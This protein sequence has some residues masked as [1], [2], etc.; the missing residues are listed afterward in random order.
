MTIIETKKMLAAMAQKIRTLK[1]ERKD[2]KNYSGHV[3]GL[4][5]LRV[6]VRY[7]HTAYCMA[8]GTPYSAI[9]PKV[10]EGNELDPVH[11]DHLISTIELPVREV[12]VEDA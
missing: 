12:E 6:D 11:L 2:K 9:E 5:S 3:P 10:A 8:Q 4:E 1:L 7:L